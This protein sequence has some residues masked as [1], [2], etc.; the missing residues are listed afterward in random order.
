MNSIMQDLRYAMRQLRRAPG[1]AATAILTLALGIGAATAVFSVIDATLLRPL[2]FANQDRLVYPETLAINGWNQPWSLPSFV[3]A[4]PQLPTFEQLA[5]Y[6]DYGRINLEGPSGPVS[7]KVTKGTDNFFKVFGIKPLL[8]RTYLPG[9]DQPGKDDVTV[10]SYEVWQREFGGQKDVVG[11]VVRLDGVP[12]TVIGVM[13]SGFRYPL[14]SLNAIYT[15]L[16][17]EPREINQRGSHWMRSVGLLKPGVTLQQAQANFSQVFANLARAYPDTDEGR[18]V[19]ILPLQQSVTGHVNGAL[20]TLGAAVLALLAI[21]CVNVAGLL[22][23]RGVK[24]EREMALRAAVGAGR[25]RIVRQM[26]T[27]SLV[28]SGAGLAIGIA[29]AYLLLAAMKAFLVSSLARGVDVRIDPAALGIALVLSGLTSILASLVPALRL[30]GTDPNKALRASGGAGTSRG[31]QRLRSAFVVTQVALSMVM[32]VVSGILLRNLSVL[33]GTKLGYPADKVLTLA[34]NPSPGRY[35]GRDPYTALYQP[36]LDRISHVPGVASA[37]LISMLPI[38][39]WGSNTGVH[40][41]GQ[42]P[43]GLHDQRWVEVRYV[44]TG[45]FDALGIRL[46]KGRMLSPGLDPWQNPAGTVVV[47]DAFQRM[48]FRG[49]GD[50]VGAHLDDN[51]KAELKTGVVGMVTGVRQDLAQPSMPEMD[52]LVDEIPPK[53]RPDALSKM[54]LV[55]RTSGDPQQLVAPI[56]EA[57]HQIDATVPFQTPLTMAQIVSESLV[58]ERME[59]WLFGIFAGLALTLALIGIY[60]LISHEVELRTR[61]IGIRM[62]LGSTRERV[63]AQILLRV[64]ILMTTGIAVGGVLTLA[65]RNVLASVIEMRVAKYPWLLVGVALAMALFGI[66]ASL[67]PA[68][69]AASIDPMQALRAE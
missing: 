14:S 1:F 29:L 18:S 54:N 42:P 62:A 5:G 10:L 65:L 21:A 39:S 23:A 33:L 36:L 48:F 50:P 9:E 12:Y 31:Q 59:N 47:N 68:R 67:L 64:A 8:G 45:Y 34:I 51:D 11:K 37:G 38:D 2:P 25:A 53:D 69:R 66:A 46:L 19:K 61:D 41:A 16:H 43:Y 56:R 27:E 35:M 52:Y 15:P 3:D 13:P 63:M 6:M 26:L 20:Y 44:S 17:P 28:L 49:G 24:R 60:G 4:R 57:L 30:S 40:I 22:L 7:L 32:L 55:V 58:F